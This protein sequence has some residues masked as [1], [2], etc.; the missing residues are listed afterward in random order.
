M[1]NHYFWSLWLQPG[2]STR[3][4]VHSVF[5]SQGP[6]T[7]QGMSTFGS[8]YT[9]YI[10][11]CN[12]TLENT[13]FVVLR[14]YDFHFSSTE[15]VVDPPPLPT[16]Y[17]ALRAHLPYPPPTQHFVPC[18]RTSSLFRPPTQNI[19]PCVKVK[20]IRLWSNI[21]VPMGSHVIRIALSRPL[22]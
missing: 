18:V 5:S 14:L 3:P 19:R 12:C 16:P 17:S 11:I 7:S 10:Y 22:Q 20:S 2:G 15:K 6:L 8:M 4:G 13:D 9:Q 21:C 1:S